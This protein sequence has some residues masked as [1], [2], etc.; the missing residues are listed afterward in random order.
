MARITFKNFLDEDSEFRDIDKEY[1]LPSVYEYA[2]TS[3]NDEIYNAI[4]KEK[5]CIQLNNKVLHPDDWALT[6]II[7]D[8][9]ILITPPF[10]GGDGGFF[11]FVLGAALIGITFIP[12]LQF[13]Q[14]YLIPVG[15]AL[16][17]G[18]ISQMLFEPDLPLLSYR[19]GQETPTYSWSGVRTMARYDTPV[20]IIYGTHKVGGNLISCFTEGEG[21]DN[22]LYMLLAL[23]EGEIK[24]I[25]KENNHATVCATTGDDP[26]VELNDQPLSE[27][28]NIEWWYRTG[29]NTQTKIRNFDG[30]RVQYDDGRSINA[31]VDGGTVYTTTKAVDM[32]TIQIR[33]PSLYDA[34][35]QDFKQHTVEYKID[36]KTSSE[37]SYHSYTFSTYTSSG[38]AVS[39]TPAHDSDIEVSYVSDETY[40][41]DSGTYT[42]TVL[43][44][45]FDKRYVGGYYNRYDYQIRVRVEGT[46][47]L[48]ELTWNNYVTWTIQQIMGSI[49]CRNIQHHDETKQVSDYLVRLNHNCKQGA[50]YTISS[51]STGTRWTQL[52]GKT[53]GDIWASHTL[54]FNNLGVYGLDVYNIKVSRR[55]EESND[56]KIS[57]EIVLQAVTEIVQ[58]SFTYPNTALL[59]L[60]IKATDQLS[61]GIP[62]VTTVIKGLKIAIPDLSGSEKFDDCYWDASQDRWEYGGAERTWDGTTLATEFSRN[63]MSCTR[64]LLLNNRYG[65]GKHLTTKDLYST[66]INT[67]IKVCHQIY[68]PYSPE[69]L[70]KWWTDFPT[71]Q[72]SKYCSFKTGSGSVDSTNRQV[73]LDGDY[74]YYSIDLKTTIPLSTGESYTT[75]TILSNLSAS[76]DI[77]I[78]GEESLKTV[79][80][81]GD[82]THTATFVCP[83][84]L[85]HVSIVVKNNNASNFNAT[86][87][88][89]SLL[90]DTSSPRYHT[91]DGVLDNEQAALTALYEMCNSFRCWPTWFEGKFNFIIDQDDT[92]IQTITMGNMIGGSFN[93]SFTPL[94]EIPYKLIGQYTDEA[95]GYDMKS[96]IAKST[97]TTLVK[98]NERTIGLKGITNRQK[99][100]REL[101]WKLNKV[102]NCTHLVNF[103]C[104]LDTIHST[105][106][107]IVNVQH[108]LPA[109]GQGGRIVESSPG[110][111]TITIDTPYTFEYVASTHLIRYQTDINT[112]VTA[113]ANASG[114]S[115]NDAT[116][117][118]TIDT[119]PASVPCTDA[120][121]AI[122]VQNAYI[123]PFRLTSV[124]RTE[125]NEVEVAGIEHHST[126]YTEPT[127]TVIEDNFSRLPNP[128]AKPDPPRNVSVIQSDPMDGIGFII[129]AKPPIG[130][131]EITDIVVQMNETNDAA[132]KTIT[133]IP[134]GKDQ[135]IYIDNGLELDRTYYFRLFCRTK[136][137]NSDIIT[138]TC[139]LKKD[140]YIVPAPAGIRLK[141]GTTAG[142]NTFK[143][144]DCTIVWEAVGPSRTKA[145]VVDGYIIEIYHDV[146]QSNTLLR[147][148]FSKDI[149]YTYTYENNIE[150]DGPY[151]TL[152]FVLRTKTVGGVESDPTPYFQASNDTPSAPSNLTAT[153]TIGGVLFTWDH[154]SADDHLIYLYRVK[155]ET[156][157]WGVWTETDG[158]SFLRTLDTTEV[159][160]HG[161]AA[162]IYIQ[163]KDKDWYNQMSGAASASTA[164]LRIPAASVIEELRGAI[165]M[166]DSDDNNATDLAELYD[167]TK[168]GGGITY[169]P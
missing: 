72:F 46:N 165:A 69:D 47:Y 12:P 38:V 84:P 129:R 152:I 11:G 134:E 125:D 27:Y 100:E 89:A 79:T 126:L 57:D 30:A 103:R 145:Y 4:L 59:G 49:M 9:E 66:G 23:G 14:P 55:Y 33:G 120:V 96:L 10:E 98:V 17:L 21:E 24:G 99:A 91:W 26:A 31:S 60:R 147:T 13:L 50:Q 139:E 25:C 148:V 56:M 63:A 133:S 3:N 8:D 22:Y 122:G 67:A 19:G 151:S 62:N 110:G 94:S 156:D 166:S 158:N 53:R 37:G 109:W 141:G 40:Y 83:K 54:D 7:E 117:I 45:E 143:G 104:G 82:G 108:Q 42:I 123:K 81:V 102:T 107:D 168:D 164:A 39:N 161:G 154:S 92:P 111:K 160:T 43:H 77:E 32:A 85:N 61:G 5:I 86:I 130:D 144:K 162:T 78:I 116:Q 159:N 95:D 70:W 80:K 71:D 48:E 146:V 112:F 97:S 76:A 93:Q 169:T 135:V 41:S 153:S 1:L 36:Y 75:K 20:P 65:L 106:G 73:T 121:Y 52:K 74:W 2:R 35:G 142:S 137:K 68:D 150:D 118:I 114:L 127:I 6:K 18:G 163:V 16:M 132:F 15:I 90:L 167:T 131:Y 87:T 124:M 101:V 138:T 64:D 157:D 140:H 136:Y 34:T 155:I 44:N 128:Y 105:A 113:T 51:T 115:D 119:F 58:G 29:T 149:E 28:D 88:G